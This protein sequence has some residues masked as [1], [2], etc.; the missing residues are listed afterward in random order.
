MDILY[1]IYAHHHSATLQQRLRSLSTFYSANFALFLPRDARWLG[2]VS[3]WVSQV[4]ILFR[5]S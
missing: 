3:E 5:N 1:T 2:W 4:R